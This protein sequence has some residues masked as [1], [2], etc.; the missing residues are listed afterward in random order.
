[1]TRKNI[2]IFSCKTNL[3]FLS[4]IDVLYVDGAF[5]S[6]PK[7]LHQLF[8]IRG[9]STGHYVTLAFF[10][11][12]NKLQTSY[13]DVSRHTISEA[14]ILSVK[15]FPTNINADF[16]TSIHNAVTTVWPGFAVKACRFHLGESW[17][18]KT[19]SFGLNKQSGKKESEVSHFLKKIFGLPLLP[20][21]EDSD[22]FASDSCPIFRPTSEWR[23]FVTT[24]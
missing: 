4:S 14:A 17:W 15:V 9:L 11:L 13:E 19:Q 16:E 8:T 20:P 12:T 24:C 18:G 5:N 21:A 3:H 23:S 22:C 2:V 7:F 10:L 6:V 1:M